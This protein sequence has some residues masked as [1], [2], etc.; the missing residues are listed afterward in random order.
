MKHCILIQAHKDID[1]FLEF[2]H[3]NKQINFYVHIDKKSDSDSI[4]FQKNVFFVKNPVKVRWGGWSQVEATL[5]LIDLALQ[6]E[7]NG[8]FH[9][10]SGEDVVLQDFNKIEYEWQNKFIHSAMIESSYSKKHQYRTR[11]N[12]VHADTD[13]QRSVLG[14][15]LT[16]LYKYLNS[17]VPNIN[18]P[19]YGSQ[20]FSLTRKDALVLNSV[21]IRYKKLFKKKLCPDEHF[22]QFLADNNDVKVANDNRRHI[23]FN[24]KYNNGNSPQ[25]LE[26]ESLLSARD[27]GF[28]FARKVKQDVALG[29]LYNYY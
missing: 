14:K 15:L 16:K 23:V 27:A 13:W 2:A 5:L 21:S 7:E 9:L 10:C 19:L 17:I 25:Y 24:E 8:Y 28:W 18:Y 29:F 22:F 11:Y 1:Y 26:I 20:W 4:S 3:M 12:Q 6:N